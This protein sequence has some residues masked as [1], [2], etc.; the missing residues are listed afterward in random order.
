M[1]KLI[2]IK[3]LFSICLLLTLTAKSFAQDCTREI[4]QNV[5]TILEKGWEGKP[6]AVKDAY[7]KKL[8]DNLY[9]LFSSSIQ[10]SKG[11][12][13][14]FNITEANEH[15]WA[16]TGYHAY[17]GMF[18]VYCRK[19]AKLDWKGL[20]NLSF[21]CS[22]NVI[23][24][25]IGNELRNEQI[26]KGADHFV[27]QDNS[28]IYVLQPRNA[29]S[30]LNGYTFIEAPRSN[31]NNAVLVTRKETPLFLP[32]TRR[33]YL[34]L[35]KKNTEAALVIQK[36]MLAESIKEKL[37]M[38][39]SINISINYSLNDTKEI[40]AFLTSHDAEY[41]NKPCIT[42]H[43]LETLF[44]KK[45]L[46][47]KDYFVNDAAD[48]KAWVI[49]NPGY[50]NKKLPANIPQFFSFTWSQGEREVEKKAALLFKE[51]FDFKK[52]EMLLQ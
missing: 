37:G 13:G 26:G 19:D 14:Y 33:Q 28:I 15:V 25:E 52:L 43:E 40:D 23:T 34:L 41:L 45:F 17:A 20:F 47:D 18:Y 49:I 30:Q 51:T 2:F 36:N 5:T 50:I 35:M 29:V 12:H 31:T 6:F 22:S 48:G 24:K 10:Q 44:G 3:L 7:G 8:G 11:L 42:N 27:Y 21:D 39:N 9:A 16:L 46:N 38:E 1:I 32:V 4:A